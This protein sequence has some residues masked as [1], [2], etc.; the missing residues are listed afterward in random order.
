[1][2]DFSNYENLLQQANANQMAN[3]S[4]INGT[5]QQKLAEKKQEI[6]AVSEGLSTPLIVEGGRG[7]LHTAFKKVKTKVEEEG[8]ET[9]KGAVKE[10][11]AMGEDFDK[12]GLKQVL[13]GTKTRLKQRIQDKIDSKL[14]QQGQ[15][16]LGDNDETDSLLSKGTKF[17]KGKVKD[18]VGDFM[19]GKPELDDDISRN[20]IKGGKTPSLQDYKDAVKQQIKRNSSKADG[21]GG[22]A[23]DGA[24]GAGEDE[25]LLS[26]GTKFLKGKAKA[27]VDDFTKDA[28]KVG[29][30]LE[31]DSTIRVKTFAKQIR[32]RSKLKQKA[33]KS[34]K[35]QEASDRLSQQKSDYKELSPESQEEY[36][37]DFKSIR[38]SQQDRISNTDSLSEARMDLN[39]SLLSKYQAIDANKGATTT[40]LKGQQQSSQLQ[41]QQQAQP[42]PDEPAPSEPEPADPALPPEP[43]APPQPKPTDDSDEKLDFKER[44]EKTGE[45]MGEEE[46]DGGGPED[47]FADLIS[48]GTGLVG[49]LGGLFGARHKHEAPIPQAPTQNVSVQVGQ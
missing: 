46:L 41:Q 29:D 7:L 38:Q 22:S 11:G 16:N 17:L 39:D 14:K 19:K 34:Q 6:L 1:M 32:E 23:E 9:A 35:Q 21:A 18:A 15:E 8:G 4:N 44:M 20:L 45:K 33:P 36:T 31:Q 27:S 43:K 26:K 30:D 10:M 2:A 3:Q 28:T 47:P 40:E 48:L 13:K 42:K 49:L 12:G 24:G 37:K 25:S 5:I